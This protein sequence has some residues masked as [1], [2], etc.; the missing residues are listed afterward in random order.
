M[1]KIIKFNTEQEAKDWD[2]E[3]NTL[4]GS[5]SKYRFSRR[6]LVET[7]TLTKAEYAEATGVPELITS[8]EGLEYANQYY[9]A[10]ESSYTLNKTAL[11]VGDAFTTYDEDGVATDHDDVETVADDAFYVSDGV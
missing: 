3:H 4:K 2:W 8:D 5:V 10:L 1:T 7:V 6:P 11:M 9:T